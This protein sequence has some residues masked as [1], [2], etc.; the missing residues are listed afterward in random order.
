MRSLA[1]AQGQLLSVLL[2][3]VSW[4]EFPLELFLLYSLGFVLR[5]EGFETCLAV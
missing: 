2:P 1:F 4:I 5:G 3:F